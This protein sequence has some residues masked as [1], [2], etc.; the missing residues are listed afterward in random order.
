[1][2]HF[3]IRDIENL[4]GIKAHTLRI[5][6]QRYGLFLCKRK[7]S[8]HRFYDNNDLKAVLRIASLYS[9][10][11]K[12]SKIAQLSTN[13]IITLASQPGAKLATDVFINQMV[14]AS[15]DFDQHRFESI[16]HSAVVNFGIEQFMLK[17]AFVFLN[18]IGDLWMTDHVIPAQ[19]HFSSNLIQR[20]L[21]AATNSLPTAPIKQPAIFFLLF[22]PEGE[23]HEIPVLFAYYMLKK[24]GFRVVLLGK[25]I[26]IDTISLFCERKK[27]SHFYFH[28]IT[29]FTNTSTLEYLLYL[30]KKFPAQKIV[31]AGKAV[32][33]INASLPDNTTVLNST[34]ELIRF[35]QLPIA[36]I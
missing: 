13:E 7:E 20:K 34:E 10:G 22:T 12:I 30:Q 11:Y 3:S 4:S 23:E 14:E 21:I 18:K 35:F 27:V 9:Q 24:K 1:M 25:N 5:W 2:Y 16:L 31:C 6:E 26:S 28:L 33:N 36:P 15:M 32:E 8:Q 29:N 19:E 17:I